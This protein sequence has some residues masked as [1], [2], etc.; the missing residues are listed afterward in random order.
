MMMQL[1]TLKPDD[2]QFKFYFS[3]YFLLL[4]G[5]KALGGDAENLQ[6]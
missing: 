1:D 6:R 3:G 2:S 4:A 5:L